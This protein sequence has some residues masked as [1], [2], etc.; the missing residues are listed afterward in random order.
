MS[1]HKIVKTILRADGKRRVLIMK[2]DHHT[3]WTFNGTESGTE[4]LKTGQGKREVHG[5]GMV[6]P[7]GLEPQ[8]S[9]VSKTELGRHSKGFTFV[10]NEMP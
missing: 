7:C 8:T 10:F 9:T 2:R 3:V 4:S 5:N 1:D 6:G